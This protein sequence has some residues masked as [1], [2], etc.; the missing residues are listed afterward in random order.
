MVLFCFLASFLHIAAQMRVR[1]IQISRICM[2]EYVLMLCMVC[3]SRMTAPL[4]KA[5]GQ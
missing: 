3:A 1:Q 2:R 5:G 4:S